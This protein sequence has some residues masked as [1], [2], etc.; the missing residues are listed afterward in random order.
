MQRPKSVGNMIQSRE[1]DIGQCKS[2]ER[3]STPATGNEKFSF[4]R[5]QASDPMVKSAG[6]LKNASVSNTVLSNYN[7]NGNGV[8][9]PTHSYTSATVQS[10]ATVHSME[11]LNIQPMMAQAECA[12]ERRP[13]NYYLFEDDST[14]EWEDEGTV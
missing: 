4:R 1:G 13:S 7:N 8:Y 14:H 3:N 2:H 12:E 5:E 6:R 9:D 10:Q 11:S